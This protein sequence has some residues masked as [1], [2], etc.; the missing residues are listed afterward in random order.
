MS[1]PPR[2]VVIRRSVDTTGTKG[3]TFE[4]KA[5]SEISS[6]EF[7][8]AG[9]PPSKI[10]RDHLRLP[11]DPALRAR[12][13]CEHLSPVFEVELAR[14]ADLT[15]GID[16]T[17][18]N[19]GE[20]LLGTV[21]APAQRLER[22]ARMIA[23]QGI[24]H[25]LFQFYTAGQ[26][27]IEFGRRQVIA[28]TSQMV[29]FDLSQ[30]AVTEAGAVAATNLM[31]P[32]AL[33]ADHIA[34]IENLHGQA[35]DYGTEPVRRLFHTYLSGL[36]AGADRIESHQARQL[37]RAAANLCGACFQPFEGTLPAADQIA[38][39]AIRQFIEAEMGSDALG[40]E[41]LITRF[42]LSRATLYRLFDADGGVANYIRE[43]RLLRAMRLL[44][45]PSGRPRV[46]AVAYATGFS[47]EKTFS[48]AFRRR[49]G[50]LPREAGIG[51]LPLRA[52]NEN[53]PVL[54][55]WMKTLAA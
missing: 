40:V 2:T 9:V 10:P 23:R 7:F 37:A 52:G 46:S 25:I 39:I 3:G 51:S 17:T 26:S 49:F 22:H 53:E 55:S 47:D 44:T 45:Q 30:P 13:W 12:A 29:V 18:Y 38:N 20:L 5:M 4:R 33:L 32:R 28:K 50:F 1:S 42:G 16:L 54:M 6:A 27:K 48:R 15:E 36:V 43:R 19:F 41:A 34:T 8:S 31:M 35:L 24:D 21:A 11:A 14:D